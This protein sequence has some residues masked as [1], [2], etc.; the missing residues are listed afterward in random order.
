[1]EKIKVGVFIG[2]I[3]VN[4]SETLNLMLLSVMTCRQLGMPLTCCD[5]FSRKCK[6]HQ[7]QEACGVSYYN[8]L[9]EA[10]LQPVTQDISSCHTWIN[11]ALTLV[12]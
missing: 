11:I 6:S 8:I 2:P 9:Q 5:W 7:L 10:H 1:M 4:S 12:P 3:Y